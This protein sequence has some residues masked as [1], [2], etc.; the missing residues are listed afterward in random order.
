MNVAEMSL[1]MDCRRAVLAG[2]ERVWILRRRIV[3]EPGWKMVFW[4]GI[5]SDQGKMYGVVIIVVVDG[6]EKQ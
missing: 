6:V 4:R 5:L 2:E 1:A 3:Q